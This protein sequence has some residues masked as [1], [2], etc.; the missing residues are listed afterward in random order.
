MSCDKYTCWSFLCVK[1]FMLTD[2][3]HGSTET[4]NG[5][6]EDKPY[7]KAEYHVADEKT[8]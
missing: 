2:E 3:Y 8:Q 1:A 5:C 6:H 4:Q 7:K